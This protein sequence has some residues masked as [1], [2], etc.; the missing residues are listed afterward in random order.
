VK[1]LG[2]LHLD[3]EMVRAAGAS[4]KRISRTKRKVRLIAGGSRIRLQ[5]HGPAARATVRRR[6]IVRYHIDIHVTQQSQLHELVDDVRRGLTA[7]RKILPPKYFYDAAGSQL[8]EKITQLPEYY[9]TRVEDSLLAGFA[10]GL[11]RDLRPLDIVELGAGSGTKTRRLLDAMHGIWPTTRYVPVDVSAT[12]L[13]TAAAQ[14][15]DEY[16]FLHVHAIVGDFQ[17][18]LGKVPLRAQRRLVL[19]L[20]STIGNL[21]PPARHDLLVE[22]RRLLDP[23]DHFLLGVD[24]EK[25]VRTLEAAYNDSA[26]ITCEF[27][28]NILRVVNRSVDADFDPEAFAHLAFYDRA[29]ARIEMHLV[30]AARQVV[31]LRRLG[32]TV[33]VAANESIWTESS[34]KFT[35]ASA[36]DALEAAGFRMAR[37]HTD[38]EQRF[39]LI[40]ATPA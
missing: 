5:G 33:E 39:A 30:P 29:A 24:L 2:A 9:L 21:D 22:V 20:G 26:G 36:R 12:T 3:S 38:P 10:A 15:V 16:P 25:D 35:Q 19:F 31:Q 28:R 17:R 27:N 8:F 18:H 4:V 14:L 11:V 32:L 40:L 23:G 34:Y 37:W 6:S 1:G 7:P 13:E